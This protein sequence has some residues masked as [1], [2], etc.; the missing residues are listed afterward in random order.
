VL[1]IGRPCFEEKAPKSFFGE[2]LVKQIRAVHDRYG[3]G[4]GSDNMRAVFCLD[5]IVDMKLGGTKVV[6]E[7]ANNLTRYGWEVEIVGLNEISPNSGPPIDMKS[8]LEYADCLRNYLRKNVS[9]FDIVSYDHCYLP[10]SREEFPFQPLFVARSVLLTQHFGNIKI[11]IYHGLRALFGSFINNP[12][13]RRARKQLIDQANRTTR[14]AD[15]VMVSNSQDLELLTSQGLDSK[16]IVVFPYSVELNRR[17]LLLQIPTS[18]P[19]GNKVA[20][21][22][23]FDVRKGAREFP[24]ILKIL[25]AGNSSIELIMLGARYR[26]KEQ[27]LAHFPRNLRSI[28]KIVPTYSSEELRNWLSQCSVGVFP[29]YVEGFPLGVLEMITSAIP[30]IAY[31]SPGAPMMLKAKY[32]VDAGDYKQLAR[33]TLDLLG[34]LKELGDARIEVREVARGYSWVDVCR[35][36]DRTFREAIAGRNKI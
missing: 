6:V 16:K 14:E 15:M 23:T 13:R 34:N 19:V 26:N 7:F 3:L 33:R 12:T 27:V 9:S 35:D 29:S 4:W 5:H 25:V 24:H 22:G 17:N 21:I 30:V 11:P 36:A 32:L 18:K 10:F 8:I 1:Q 20:Y 28:I 31:R 2:K